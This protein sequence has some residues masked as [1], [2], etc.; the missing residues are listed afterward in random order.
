MFIQILFAEILI[1]GVMP[2]VLAQTTGAPQQASNTFNPN[3][4]VVMDILSTFGNDQ[5]LPT[6]AI[7]VNEA[8]VA[9]QSVVDPYGRADV[10]I[11]YSPADGAVEVEEAYFTWLTMPFSLQAKVGKF[12]SSFGK[13]NLTHPPE[14]GLADRPLAALIFLGE[15][16][17]AS[18]GVSLSWLVPTSG[19]YLKLIGEVTTLWEETPAFS[20]L[21]I[22]SSGV[23]ELVTSERKDDLGYLGRAETFFNIS[24]ASNLAIGTS[25]AASVNNPDGDLWT[26]LW[27]IDLIFRWKN[28]RR[29]V[30]RSVTWRAE[31]LLNDREMPTGQENVTSFGIFSILDWQFSKRWHLGGRGDFSEF[32]ETEGMNEKGGLGY[33]TFT[34]SEFSLVSLQGR[35]VKRSDGKDD[36]AGFIKLTFNIGPHGAHPF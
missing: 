23:E 4:S 22:D 29:A 7:N 2:A 33:I 14:T 20:T 3:I 19:L 18:T 25:F 31:A 13:F 26:R 9:F 16:G 32:P 10:I 12:R 34:P 36:T 35:Y 11:S 27:G 30:Y 24:E 15:E 5:T 1:L 28:P 17:L 21:E 6:Q 8:E